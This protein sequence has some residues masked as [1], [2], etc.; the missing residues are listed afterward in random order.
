MEKR[1][2]G[3]TGIMAS[4]IALGSWSMGGDAQWGQRDDGM[5]LRTIESAVEQGINLIDTAP[6]YG[7]GYSE[8]LV[9]KAISSIPRDKILIETKC[10]FW[11]K[12]DEGAVIIERDGKVCRRNLSKRAIMVD[13]DDSLKN[14]GIDY[15]DIYVTHHQARAPFLFPVSETMDAL[16]ELKKQGKI[17][18]IGISN[19]T[20]EEADAYLACGTVDLIQERFSMLDRRKAD[21]FLPTCRERGITFQ[22]FSPLEQGLLSG[23][24]RMDYKVDSINLRKNIS[25]YQPDKREKVLKMLDGWKNLCEKYNCSTAS[26][27]TA[28]TAAVSRNIIVI[29][30]ARKENHL[31]DYIKGGELNLDQTDFDNMNMDV[32]VLLEEAAQ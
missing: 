4:K 15:I 21:M 7:F 31:K 14:L 16:Q 28:W 5:S 11:W 20:K 13:F 2:I 19:C 25:W 1:E 27:V 12:D 9:G 17:R 22:G 24:I 6:A 29:A 30:G 10:G 8:Q 3:R 26:L 32:A 18:A 23:T